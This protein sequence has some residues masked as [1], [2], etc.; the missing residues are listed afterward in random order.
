MEAPIFTH[1]YMHNK[2]RFYAAINRMCN[3]IIVQENIMCEATNGRA[4]GAECWSAVA[5]I[6]ALCFVNTRYY[7]DGIC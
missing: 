3:V 2:K 1:T 7:V 5:S 6:L 4:G